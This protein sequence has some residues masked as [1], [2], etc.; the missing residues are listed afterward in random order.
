MKLERTKEWRESRGLTQRELAAAANVG[1]PSIPRIERGQS[2][3]PPTARK[4]A[5]AL[6]ITVADLQANPPM[7]ATTTSATSPIAGNL[8]PQGNLAGK[9]EG[10][11]WTN[12]EELPPGQNDVA[13]ILRKVGASTRYL[14]VDGLTQKLK[15]APIEDVIKISREARIEG[16]LIMPEVLRLVEDAEEGTTEFV[17]ATTAWEDAAMR[18]HAL[19]LLLRVKRSAKLKEIPPGG[20]SD[21]ASAKTSAEAS[22]EVEGLYDL[23]RELESSVG[24]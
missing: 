4:I 5:A 2:V 19:Q 22:A 21:P 17:R 6:G 3:T 11:Y 1:Q 24:S 9:A 12:L 14:A 7:P 13:A 18:L 10:S 20:A 23:E 8:E 15:D 16:H